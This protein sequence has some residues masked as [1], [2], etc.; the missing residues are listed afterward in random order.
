[1]WPV[2]GAALL[3]GWAGASQRNPLKALGTG[4]TL[5]LGILLFLALAGLALAVIVL[6]F[7][8]VSG[9][10][11]SYGIFGVIAI[12]LALILYKLDQLVVRKR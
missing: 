3:I 9:F 4:I 1:M 12:L 11:A 10:L 2:I 5:L 8:T 7:A 6:G